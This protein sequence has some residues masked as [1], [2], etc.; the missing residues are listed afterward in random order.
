MK[1]NIEP[2]IAA[3]QLKRLSLTQLAAQVGVTESMIRKIENGDRASEKTIFKMSEV[4]DVPMSEI[5]PPKT[6][7]RKRTAEKVA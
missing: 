7:R 4:L 3:R 1:Y 2:L 6:K 5:L